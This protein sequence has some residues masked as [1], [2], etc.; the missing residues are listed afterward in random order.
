MV[1]WPGLR[2]VR[3]SLYISKRVADQRWGKR[4]GG[5]HAVLV[6]DLDVPVRGTAQKD[7]AVERRPLHRVHWTLRQHK[8]AAMTPR[9]KKLIRRW[10]SER[11]L[12]YDDIAH[13][14]QNT[15]KEP[16]SF[17]KLNDSYTSTAH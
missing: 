3:K 6:P 4:E 1:V 14:L 13:L 12:F 15:T 5:V 17:S 10:D 7:V 2:Y 11:E 16:T 8:L 9:L